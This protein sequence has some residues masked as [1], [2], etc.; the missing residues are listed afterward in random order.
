VQVQHCESVQSLKICRIPH[1]RF[2]GQMSA[3]RRQEVLERFSI[4]LEVKNTSSL[5]KRSRRSTAKIVVDSDDH[6]SQDS[7]AQE[8]DLVLKNQEDDDDSFLDDSDDEVTP[9]TAKKG[10][11]KATP[12]PKA[13]RRSQIDAFSDY[14]NPVVMLISLKAGALGLNLTVANN[15]S[16]NTSYV[17]SS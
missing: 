14:R 13:K 3:R 11:A 5:P 12:K 6:D 16:A 1:V 9:W 4:P 17:D 10:K 8:S 7:P 2:D 15:V